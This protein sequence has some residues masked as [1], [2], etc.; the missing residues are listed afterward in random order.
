MIRDDLISLIQQA[1]RKAQA[2]GDLPI[3]VLP[4]FVVERPKNAEHGD[5]ST[6]VAMQS[7]RLAKMA[8]VKIALPRPMAV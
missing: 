4:D 7:A 3:F 8:P 2:S 6:N 5:Y 1:A